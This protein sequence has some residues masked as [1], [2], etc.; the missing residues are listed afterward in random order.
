MIDETLMIKPVLHRLPFVTTIFGLALAVGAPSPASAQVSKKPGAKPNPEFLMA[1][2]TGKWVMR[3]TINDE[4]VTHDVT[5][6]R[7]L[8]R[9]YVRIHEI[10]REKDAS[11]KPAY[12]AWIHIAWDQA[13]QEFAV[14]WLD[15]T[16]ITNFSA[17]GVGHGKPQGDRIP[18]VWKLADGTGIRNTFAFD[19]PSNS[20]SWSIDNVDKAG[21]SS[22]F[23]RVTLRRK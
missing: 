15:N 8:N 12:E 19:R 4:K 16:G 1:K 2:M 5:V 3:G 22:P 6:D 13:N 21:K 18:F 10:S 9:Q 23:G 14:M 11:G 20:W 17:D 7:I